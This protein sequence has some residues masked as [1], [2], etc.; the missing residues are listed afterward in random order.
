MLQAGGDFET[1]FVILS[2]HVELRTVSGALVEQ[3]GQ[4]AVLWAVNLLFGGAQEFTATAQ[5]QVEAAMVD[6]ATV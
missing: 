2:G 1:G 5:D 4:G 3:A 6:R